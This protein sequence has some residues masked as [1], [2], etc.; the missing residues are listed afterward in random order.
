MDNDDLNLLVMV[1]ADDE[2]YIFVWR[3]EYQKDLLMALSRYASNP[4]LSLTWWDT[5]A[6]C[7]RIRQMEMEHGHEEA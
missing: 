3:P 1:R 7:S 4:D 6:L 2:K 5:C